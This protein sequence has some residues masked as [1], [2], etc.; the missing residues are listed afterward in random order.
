VH[1]RRQAERAAGGG[2][3]GA[4]APENQDLSRDAAAPQR[5]RLLEDRDG[6]PVDAFAGEAPGDGDRAVAVGVRLDDGDERA[7]SRPLAQQPEVPGDRVEVDDRAGRARI[8][9]GQN[10]SPAGDGAGPA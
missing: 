9:F 7:A 3:R 1:G 5:D 2:L 4:N 10:G 8:A 6:E